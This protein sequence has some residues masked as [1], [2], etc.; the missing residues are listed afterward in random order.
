MRRVR[1]KLP[2]WLTELR[3]ALPEEGTVQV[4]IPS[5]PAAR[6][7]RIS[8]ADIDGAAT[9]VDERRLR[10]QRRSRS[11]L[12]S[13]RSVLRR[14][15]MGVAGN[16]SVLSIALIA[17]WLDRDLTEQVLLAERYSAIERETAFDAYLRATRHL[18]GRDIESIR[19]ELAELRIDPEAVASELARIPIAGGSEGI[20]QVVV[21][22][23]GR[24]DDEHEEL[25]LSSLDLRNFLTSLPHRVPLANASITSKFGLRRHPIL[26]WMQLH[27]GIDYVTRGDPTVVASQ[28]GAVTLARR[29]AGYGLTVEI[30]ND[31]G[32]VSRYGHLRQ[33]S[34]K[35]GDQVQS[36][37][38]IGI[39][40]STGLTTGPHLH[41]EILVNGVP[42][43]PVQILRTAQN[44]LEEAAVAP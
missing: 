23:Q 4:L 9:A 37:D 35:V 39:M 18:L 6:Y 27:E 19:N 2:P 1:S 38:P 5:R 13:K 12:R 40:G 25:L 17:V 32:V 31:Y 21:A 8:R 11:I 3:E 22:L 36:G 44:A 29:S 7:L 10:R 28:S 26:R 30:T 43:D 16:L 24:M 14:I 41:Y 20:H 42:L 33:F 34:V 15:A